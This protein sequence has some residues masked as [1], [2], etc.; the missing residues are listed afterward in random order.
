MKLYDFEFKAL[1]RHFIYRRYIYPAEIKDLN[2]V[3]KEMKNQFF[4]SFIYCMKI[5]PKGLKTVTVSI[6]KIDFDSIKYTNSYK[7]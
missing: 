4:R 5:N 3:K 2:I 1:D 6:D 7:C